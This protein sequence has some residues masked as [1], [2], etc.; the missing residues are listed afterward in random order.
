MSHG[1][2]GPSVHGQPDCREAG[3]ALQLVMQTDVYLNM[4]ACIERLLHGGLHTFLKLVLVAL[5]Q[6][7]LP[8][9]PGHR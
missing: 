9:S 7:G 5:L 2:P 6:A 1:S 3:L 4:Q 8:L